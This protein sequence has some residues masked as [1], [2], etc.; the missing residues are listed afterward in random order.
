M[1]ANFTRRVAAVSGRSQA[2]SR[3]SAG[4]GA[5]GGMTRNYLTK[6]NKGTKG[7]VSISLSTHPL[8][9]FVRQGEERFGKL[10][11]WMNDV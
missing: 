8:Y 7:F 9:S 6:T 4:M 10:E 5:V 1:A 3:L 2:K 11:F